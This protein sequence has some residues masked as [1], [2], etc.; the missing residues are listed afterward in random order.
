MQADRREENPENDVEIP[1]EDFGNHFGIAPGFRLLEQ[2]GKNLPG[3]WRERSNHFR[4]NF[5]SGV[6]ARDRE[7]KVQ[8]EDQGQEIKARLSVAPNVEVLNA[9]FDQQ[10]ME[11][12]PVPEIPPLPK[13]VSPA[14]ILSVIPHGKKILMLDRI[15]AGDEEH[16][17]I[18]ERS[19][20]EA[21]LAGDNVLFKM[22]EMV[23]QAG[24]WFLL[25]GAKR[26]AAETSTPIPEKERRATLFTEF[27][28]NFNTELLRRLAVGDKLDVAAFPTGFCTGGG[29][30]TNQAGESL[31]QCSF[32]HTKPLPRRA[33]S[34]LVGLGHSYR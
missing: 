6:L 7:M 26:A 31:L 14:E 29:R 12:A 30:V 9:V 18:G 20:T 21:D 33:V 8:V 24:S 1:K 13:A 32:Q 25:G 34:R 11:M 3:D 4:A 19:L 5:Q 2:V 17:A 15:V 23:G 27:Q 10:P 22:M 16:G 28:A